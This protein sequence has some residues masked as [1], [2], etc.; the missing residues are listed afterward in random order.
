MAQHFDMKSLSFG[1]IRSNCFSRR[2]RSDLDF[3]HRT[4]TP[5]QLV[6]RSRL[7]HFRQELPRYVLVLVFMLACPLRGSGGRFGMRWGGG[8]ARRLILR[9]LTGL[10]AG[11][12]ASRN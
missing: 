1:S 8:R 2:R 7:P 4:Q 12:R 9:A 10:I 11:M 3:V 6:Y 5:R